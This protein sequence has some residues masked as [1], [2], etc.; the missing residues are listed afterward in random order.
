MA[1]P[2]LQ[3]TAPGHITPADTLMAGAVVVTLLWLGVTGVRTYIPYIVPMSLYIVAGILAAAF[4][5]YHTRGLLAVGQDIG[6]LA[7]AAAIANAV[8]TPEGFGTVIR[9]WVYGATAW[10][11]ALVLAMLTHQWWLAGGPNPVS[12][13][14]LF[15]VIPNI[16]GNFFALSFFVFLL[17]D[18]PRSVTGRVVVGA[19]LLAAV[20]MTGS[21][22]ALGSLAIGGAATVFIAIWRRH[23]LVAAVGSFVMLL[24]MVGIL[25]LFAY[26]AGAVEWL[27]STSNPLVVH[28]VD[29]SVRS[30]HGRQSLFPAVFD[31][32]R[33]GSPIGIGPAATLPTLL[34]EGAGDKSA[35]N[36]YLA[37]IVERGPVGFIGLVILIV[38]LLVRTFTLALKPI[39]SAY[40]RV[41]RNPAAVVGAI[42]TVWVT[43]FTHEVLH[44][45]QV[46]AFFGLLAGLYLFARTRRAEAPRHRSCP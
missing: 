1:L 45:R 23:D 13:G 8:R 39:A 2:L 37:T 9:A 44:Y 43:G 15:F 11:A 28:S 38:G 12:R 31:L 25:V 30:A 42:I 29:R 41:V 24:T 34:A 33:D 26:E 17:G 4:S 32:Y 3:P 20:A 18:S 14:S 19:T 10:G 27:G 16:A 5:T 40:E 6:L 21:N 36:D 22:A 35:H 46:W 7:W